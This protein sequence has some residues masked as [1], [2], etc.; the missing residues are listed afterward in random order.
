MKFAIGFPSPLHISSID[1]IKS[2]NQP[3]WVCKLH[4]DYIGWTGHKNL[5]DE[6]MFS[7]MKEHIPALNETSGGLN[8]CLV[9]GGTIL[10]RRRYLNEI[11][12]YKQ[13]YFTPGVGVSFP[14]NEVS[15]L[16]SM[17]MKMSNYK[18][19][20]YYENQWSEIFNEQKMKIHVRGPISKRRLEKISVK[21]IIS[22]DTCFLI[23][24]PYGSRNFKNKRKIGINWGN[25]WPFFADSRLIIKQDEKNRQI[26]NVIRELKKNYTIT[27]YC[28]YP[29]DKEFLE[30]LSDSL[31]IQLI[32]IYEDYPVF[33]DMVMQE[34]IVLGFKMHFCVL[35]AVAGRPFIIINYENNKKAFDFSASIGMNKFCID[36]SKSILKL[37]KSIEFL[38]NNKEK[39]SQKILKNID[40]YRN[41]QKEYLTK[42]QSQIT[43][44]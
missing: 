20:K 16:I 22:G 18:E 14:Y 37:E 3:V 28:I 2:S 11:K 19:I 12:K 30:K 36:I 26:E 27:L 29:G 39:I 42:L 10:G 1:S 7:I 31:K 43:T 34:D 17:Q 21:P 4:M 41:I 15:S 8:K 35:A 9:G 23:E 25:V 44:T 13:V 38:Y 33:L 40:Y 6:A 32:E 5:G 24:Q